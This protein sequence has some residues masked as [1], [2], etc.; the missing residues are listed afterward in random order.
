MLFESNMA[1]QTQALFLEQP[2]A[3]FVSINAQHSQV[4]AMIK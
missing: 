4:E 2:Q 3:L 1:S